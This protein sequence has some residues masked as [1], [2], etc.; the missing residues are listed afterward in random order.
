MPGEEKGKEGRI[1]PVELA[2]QRRTNVGNYGKV[3]INT[4]LRLPIKHLLLYTRLLSWFSIFDM[5]CASLDD[6]S[7]LMPRTMPGIPV[8][9][10]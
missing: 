10:Q 1:F 9:A 8:G 2:E 5:V 4:D 3:I 6:G 7:V